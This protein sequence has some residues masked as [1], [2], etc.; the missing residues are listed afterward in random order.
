VISDNKLALK[1]RLR[2]LGRIEV[3]QAQ[4]RHGGK[5]E[6]LSCLDPAVPG[7]DLVVMADQDRVGEAEA[8]RC[9]GRS[10]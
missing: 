8:L 1:S 7:D 4:R 3:R 6:E 9:C 2:R 10:A 5:P